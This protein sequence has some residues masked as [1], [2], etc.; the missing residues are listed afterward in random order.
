MWQCTE[1]KAEKSPGFT[2]GTVLLV[3]G[4][5]SRQKGSEEGMDTGRCKVHS[6]DTVA[7]FRNFRKGKIIWKPW[8]QQ[9][10]SCVYQDPVTSKKKLYPLLWSVAPGL[11]HFGI[12]P[13]STLFAWEVLP[14]IFLH[15]FTF[16][17]H[18]MCHFLGCSMR[19]SVS[20]QRRKWEEQDP[21]K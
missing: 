20:V 15:Q 14:L 11:P 13:H 9:Q 18:L 8:T 12:F 2:E 3:A 10:S 16:T 1:V 5:H 17:F 19:T 6:G 7:R 4:T 21:V